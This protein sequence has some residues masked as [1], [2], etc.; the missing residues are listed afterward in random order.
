MIFKERWAPL[1]GERADGFYWAFSR[2]EELMRPY[3][4]IVETG[5][6]RDRYRPLDFARDGCST[7]LFDRCVQHTGG[8]CYSVDSSA[9]A[10][11]Y[12]RQF[13]SRQTQ[14]VH[15]D[16][17]LFLRRLRPHRTIDLL[18][19]DSLDYDKVNPRASEERHLFELTAAMRWLTPGSVIM[20]DDNYPDGSGKGALIRK[21]FI[22]SGLLPTFEGRQLGWV[23]P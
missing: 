21:F 2:L 1:L 5:C 15:D 20:V 19:L 10:V 9:R 6:M 13:V 23:L 3:R 4:L 14:V 17:L 16:S 11:A 7:L 8:A 22:H 18:Y 12:A